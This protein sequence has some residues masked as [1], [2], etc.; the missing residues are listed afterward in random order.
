MHHGY[1]FQIYLIRAFPQE[2]LIQKT[3]YV[4]QATESIAYPTLN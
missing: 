1:T 2:T 4:Q 3:K